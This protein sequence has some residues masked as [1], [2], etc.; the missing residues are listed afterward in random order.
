MKPDTSR[1][2]TEGV[3]WFLVDVQRTLGLSQDEI[4]KETNMTQ[5]RLSQL[6]TGKAEPTKSE[7]VALL[8]F[9]LRKTAMREKEILEFSN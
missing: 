3:Q 7:R 8:K 2:L 4:A 1:F 6:E 9:L 5:P